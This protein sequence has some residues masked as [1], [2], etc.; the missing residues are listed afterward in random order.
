MKSLLKDASNL[1]IN[2]SKSKRACTDKAV[3]SILQHTASINKS[4]GDPLSGGVSRWHRPEPDVKDDTCNT[5]KQI[6]NHHNPS[7]IVQN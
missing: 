1:Q 7:W 2:S 4:R 3:A 6:L 5:M